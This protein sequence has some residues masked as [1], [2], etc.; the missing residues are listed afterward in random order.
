MVQSRPRTN[1]TPSVNAWVQSM[2]DADVPEGKIE[3]VVTAVLPRPKETHPDN[4]VTLKEA[5]AETG[6]GISRLKGWVH[7]GILEPRDRK[8][9]PARGGGYLLVDIEDV[10]ALKEDPPKPGRPYK[11]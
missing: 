10:R 11:E 4:W 2:R 8:K 7:R 1:G 9:A 6:L 3:Q 5:S